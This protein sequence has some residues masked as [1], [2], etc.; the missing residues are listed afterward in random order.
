MAIGAGAALLAFAIAS[1]IPH[2]RAAAPA[3]AAAPASA[4]SSAGTSS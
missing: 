3:A 2:P 1:F 4:Q